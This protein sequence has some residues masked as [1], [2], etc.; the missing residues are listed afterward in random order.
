LGE[1]GRDQDIETYCRFLAGLGKLEIPIASY[2]F[3]PANTYTTKMVEH[4]G[5]T[6]RF[7]LTSV[8]TI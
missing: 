8:G 3:R 1:P 7:L 5:Y 4:R 2:D 6:A